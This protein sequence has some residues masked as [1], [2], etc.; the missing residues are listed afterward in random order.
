MSK[1]IRAFDFYENLMGATACAYYAGKQVFIN[2][3]TVLDENGRFYHHYSITTKD[4]VSHESRRYRNYKKM[5]V[6]AAKAASKIL[7]IEKEKSLQV[8]AEETD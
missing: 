5:A 8:Q 6:N 4:G 1:K 7:K 2:Y 3:R